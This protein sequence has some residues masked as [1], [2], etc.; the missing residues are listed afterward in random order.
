MPPLGFE[1]TRRARAEIFN[2]SDR[3]AWMEP[4]RC[5]PVTVYL[6]L[7]F[8]PF[9]FPLPS[10]L[11]QRLLLRGRAEGERRRGERARDGRLALGSSGREGHVGPEE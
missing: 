9:P 2:A 5:R 6:R 11:P 4:S 3:R 8:S 7:L 1:V 10:G